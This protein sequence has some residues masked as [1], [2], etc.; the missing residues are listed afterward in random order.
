MKGVQYIK[1][2]RKWAAICKGEYLGLFS[3]AED[4]HKAY[5]KRA[6]ELYGEFYKDTS[7]D[8]NFIIPELP[9]K[10]LDDMFKNIDNTDKS[11]I[12]IDFS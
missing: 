10:R 3:V 8:I 4:A 5:C 6:K 12:N 9:T 7:S 2:S 1:A 11:S